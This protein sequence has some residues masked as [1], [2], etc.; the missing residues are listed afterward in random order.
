MSY[1]LYCV[2]HSGCGTAMSPLPTV[3][4]QQPIL[5]VTSQ[6]LSA[7]VAACAA[8]DMEP[9]VDTLLRYGAIVEA[10]HR[11][12]DL[13]P[14]RYGARFATLAAVKRL[15][16]SHHLDYLDQLAR[17]EAC[18]EMTLRILLPPQPQDTP[19]RPVATG[20]DY[21][22]W[23]RDH[24]AT[25][26]RQRRELEQIRRMLDAG[27]QGHYSDSRSESGTLGDR[28]VFSLHY[29]VRR[30]RL[31]A[32]SRAIEGIIAA[33]PYRL[34]LSGPWPAYHFVHQ[35]DGDMDRLLEDIL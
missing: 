27:L 28:Q 12:Y 22:Q 14:M 11:Q 21:L 15:L 2:L 34:L 29:L 20:A 31:D 9:D 5:W 1:L 23:R 24:Y 6:G 7:A 35:V 33:V 19:S 4:A 3:V 30:Q 17:V 25:G 16:Q 13:L 10:L 18:A 26:G 8:G 32:F